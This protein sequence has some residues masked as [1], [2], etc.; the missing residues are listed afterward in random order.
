MGLAVD[1]RVEYES[2]SFDPIQ[3]DLL[4]ESSKSDF[5][6]SETIAT[7]NFDL[8]QTHTHIDL[9]GLM[10]LGSFDL[11]RPV[12]HDDYISRLMTHMLANFEYVCV[13]SDWAE[14]FDKLKRALTCAALLWWMH[15]IW[16]QL[17]YFFC[18]DL[19][20]S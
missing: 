10:D 19:I 5:V 17:S 15:F 18:V 8:D 1:L 7:E 12:I 16:L 11:P 4:F 13:F 20:E 2:F 3:A 6:E 14:Q 9:K